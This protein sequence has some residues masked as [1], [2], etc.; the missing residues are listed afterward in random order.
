MFPA[1]LKP[2]LDSL[3]VQTDSRVNSHK[4]FGP[5][6]YTNQPLA[7]Q[8]LTSLYICRCKI[9]WSD[10]EI[11][12]WLERNVN[13]VLDKVDAKDEIVAEFAAKRSQRYVNP[14]R[15]ILRHIVLSDFKEKVPLAH[16]LKKETDI[17][18]YDPLPPID[19]INV[20]QR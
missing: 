1:V 15:P 7:L 9:V 12:P 19:S 8:Q 14:P 4:Y 17:L 18:M 11:L 10:A 2:L 6:A 16:F 13:I 20:Y 3:S 5:S